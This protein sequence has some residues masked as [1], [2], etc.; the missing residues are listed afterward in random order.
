MTG[1]DHENG[2]T[3][4]ETLI[5]MVLFATGILAVTTLQLNSIKGNTRANTLT[6]AG[7]AAS[8]QSEELRTLPFDDPH[9][10]EGVHGPRSHGRLW[11]GWNV[12]CDTPFSPLTTDTDGLPMEPVSL[13]KT[14]DIVVFSD[15][16]G[17]DDPTEK[18]RLF[19]CGFVKT[20]S[21]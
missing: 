4:I 7:S 6:L 19:T 17:F 11:V 5:A 21:L 8:D 13:C 12:I 15:S 3:L 16:R 20:R 1:Y 2:F 9:L 18:N 14:V 10:T